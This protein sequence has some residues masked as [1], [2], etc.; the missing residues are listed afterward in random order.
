MDGKVDMNL[1]VSC[2]DILS[3]LA[4]E[5]NPG[6]L[7]KVIKYMLTKL[8]GAAKMKYETEEKVGS[9]A[10]RSIMCCGGWMKSST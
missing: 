2:P 3:L 8:Y 4:S 9:L 5:S 6:Y 7:I 10:Q 1:K